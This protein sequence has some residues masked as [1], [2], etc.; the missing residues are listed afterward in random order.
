MISFSEIEKLLENDLGK[1]EPE[2]RQLAR[3]LVDVLNNL[4]DNLLEQ[5]L[6]EEERRAIHQMI[7]T[8]IECHMRGLPAPSEEIEFWMQMLNPEVLLPVDS[9]L[10]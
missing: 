3:I 2:L 10:Q 5:D 7:L 9:G 6:P 4:D 1:L 8:A